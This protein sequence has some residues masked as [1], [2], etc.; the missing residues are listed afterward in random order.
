VYAVTVFFSEPPHRSS[1][2]I[3]ALIPDTR[4]VVTSCR[5]SQYATTLVPSRDWLYV[6]ICNKGKS[7][8][9][10]DGLCIGSGDHAGVPRLFIKIG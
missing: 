10:L 1:I 4:P 5:S 9:V 8:F 2:D 3:L 7:L 6:L